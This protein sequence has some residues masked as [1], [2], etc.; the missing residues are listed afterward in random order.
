MTSAVTLIKGLKPE[1]LPA[2]ADKARA[3]RNLQDLR[4]LHPALDRALKDPVFSALCTA[5]FGGSPYLARLAQRHNGWLAGALSQTPQAALQRILHS[6]AV[7]DPAALS[8]DQQMTELRNA[9]QRAALLIALCDIAG[10][11][12]LATITKALSD[13]AD[14]TL[15]A[16]LDWLFANAAT[17]GKFM[18]ADPGNPASFA[19]SSGLALIA[20]GKYG[21]FELNYSSDI[22]LIVLY[23]AEKAP[24]AEGVEAGDF[25][26]RLTRNLVK[27]MQEVTEDGYVFRTDLRLR[28]DPGS[29]SIAVNLRAAEQYYETMGQNWER[30]AMIKAR[31]VAGDIDT[32]NEFLNHL[33]PFIWRKYLDYAAIEDVHSMK[34]Q[35][36]AFRGHGE[37]AVKGHNIKLGR[38][39][40]REIEFFVQTQQLIAGGR[41]EQLRDNRT[42]V[43]LE[44]LRDKDWI[45]AQ[46]ADQLREAYEFLRTIEHRL[47]MQNDE[48]LHELPD[49]D[50]GLEDFARFAGFRDGQD[51]SQTLTAHLQNVQ[52]HYAALFEKSESLGSDQGVLVFTGTEED[53]ETVETIAT[54]G[55]SNASE[56]SATIRGWHFGRITAT[57]SARARERLTILVP[58]LLSALS[59]TVDPDQAFHRFDQFIGNLPAGVQLFS[60]LCSNPDM[61]DFLAEIMGTAPRLAGGLARNPQVL[62]AAL[63]PG[64]FSILPA[65]SRIRQ[66]LA[67][68]IAA[69]NDFEAVLDAARVIAREQGFR[70]G[71]HLLS[72]TA[73]GETAGQAYTDLADCLI[74]GLVSVVR[75]E[76]E[77][78]HGRL[79]D[80]EVA[81]L[82]LGKLGG[83]EM[84]AS[85][86]LDLILVYDH[87]EDCLESD[88]RKPLMAGQYYARFTQHL[89][90]ALTAPTAQGQLYQVDM[91]LRPSG[92]SGP[93]ATRFV[94][95]TDYQTG[96][97]WAWEHMA[98]TRARVVAGDRELSQRLE[99]AIRDILLQPRD[100]KETASEIADM[101]NRIFIEKGSDDIWD[102]KQTRGGLVEL[103]FIAQTLQLI[104]GHDHPDLLSTNTAT[105]FRKAILQGLLPRDQGERLVAACEFLHDLTQIIRLCVEGKFDAPAANPTLRVLLARAGDAPD[106]TS[107]ENNLRETQGLIHRA[108]QQFVG[109]SAPLK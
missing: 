71:A 52:R 65:K 61:L 83:C 4:S 60:L 18:P 27:L 2:P 59:K 47:Q 7:S 82:A 44:I 55:F 69:A 94:S 64:F 70:I 93:I 95:F 63:D 58:L 24:L 11:W 15:A 6:L 91:R 72:N 109:K 28:P 67:K 101:R 22:D 1:H 9:K 103:E 12:D 108:Y 96:Q 43:M 45:T 78:R 40:I 51:F 56:I 74:E 86:D 88:G 30:A 32:G 23:D 53:P 62:D 3:A 49:K 105:M 79:K 66:N 10:L 42:L 81:I 39:G 31:A 34:R 89:I 87:D 38:G 14:S 77:N 99:A 68:A 41:D 33:T 17:S 8:E 76:M 107:L 50:A 98:L 57:R 75:A 100:A 35:V 102:I 37:I 36:H 26:V 84:T 25:F 19:Q 46:A 21:A 54:M 106:F 80:G 13:L 5:A 73:N 104:Q 29:T 92:Q 20:M 90:S 97:A 48:Q 16:A 85:S